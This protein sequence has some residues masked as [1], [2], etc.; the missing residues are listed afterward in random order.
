MTDLQ[1]HF[2]LADLCT[3]A[4]LVP[5]LS[6]QG[7]SCVGI[8]YTAANEDCCDLNF[9]QARFQIGYFI[10][11]DVWFSDAESRR[12]YRMDLKN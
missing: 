5:E 8:H 3:Y 11:H 2:G 1:R 10:E 7:I 6:E 12:L 9:E 4:D